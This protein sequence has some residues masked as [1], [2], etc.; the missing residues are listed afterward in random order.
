MA[1]IGRQLVLVVAAV[2]LGAGILGVGFDAPPSAGAPDTATPTPDSAPPEG[3]PTPEPEVP[4]TNATD[5]SVLVA[6][7]T[8]VA[9]LAG[10]VATQLVDSFGY[11]TLAPVDSTGEPATTSLVFYEPGSEAEAQKIAASLALPA[12][13]VAPMPAAAPVTDLAGADVLVL[14]GLD[15]VPVG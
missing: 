13:S 2:A 14:I 15:K 3:D 10:G 12:G 9:G 8:G 4:A 11:T 7:S 5:T 6:N 1:K